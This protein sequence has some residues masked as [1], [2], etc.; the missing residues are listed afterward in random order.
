MATPWKL[1]AKGIKTNIAK[2]ISKGDINLLN[3][4]TYKFINILSGFIAH[5]DIDGFK[6]YYSNFN[7]FLDDLRNSFDILNPQRYN[8]DQ[9]FS[10]SD[11]KEYYNQKCEVIQ[12]IADIISK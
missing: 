8:Y 6:D 12:F 9:F 11:Q 1:N 10:K 3:Q 2:V 5:Y 7:T 4:D